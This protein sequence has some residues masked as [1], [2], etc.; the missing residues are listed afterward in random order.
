M[1]I[2][3]MMS[4]SDKFNRNKWY[5]R[6]Y[7]NDMKLQP[8]TTSQ[9]VFYSVDKIPLQK[10]TLA[11]GSIKKTI[12]TITIETNDVV[13]GLEVDDYVLYGDDLWLVDNIIA[14][15]YNTAKEFTKRP[16]FTT[17]IRLRK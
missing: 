16:S 13:D 9:G 8:G 5:R 12:Y 14:N 2:D 11:T 3:L 10:Q 4:R 1:G 17:E 15:D 7:V 6:E